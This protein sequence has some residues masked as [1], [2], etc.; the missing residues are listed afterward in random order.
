MRAVGNAAILAVE[1]VVEAAR[2]SVIPFVVLAIS[3]FLLAL[4]LPP[5]WRKTMFS[6][7]WIALAVA[8]VAYGIYVPNSP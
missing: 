3:L 1:G 4:V 8:L 2:R 6:L 5:A 7:A